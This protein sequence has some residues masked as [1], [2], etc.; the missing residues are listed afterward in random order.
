MSISC[1]AKRQ[2]IFYPTAKAINKV[3][4]TEGRVHKKAF[5]CSKA[6]RSL[7]IAAK[8]RADKGNTQVIP[9]Y[10]CISGPITL[11][12]RARETGRGGRALG[13]TVSATA[14]AASA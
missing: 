9:Q 3:F 2:G 1:A 4:K 5:R 11:V 8:K 7:S 12:P 14:A 10:R 13:P 6:S